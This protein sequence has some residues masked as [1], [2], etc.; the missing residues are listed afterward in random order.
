[1]GRQK[2]SPTPTPNGAGW[3]LK[4]LLKEL[5][6]AAVT[7]RGWIEPSD[8]KRYVLPILFLRFHSLRYDR[9][10]VELE[11]RIAD[12]NSDYHPTDTKAAA[13]ILNDPDEYQAAGAF[14]VP[15]PARWANVAAAARR[16]DVKLQVDNLL[17]LLETSYPTPLR[18]LLPR[19]YADPNL[20]A[21]NLRGLIN[22]FS[23]Y[24]FER[25]QP[26]TS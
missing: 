1:M 3:S 8:Y 24:E 20:D 19:I 7:L 22:L 26:A 4:E 18:S 11:R 6:E 10:R 16:D 9:R 15:E 17:E 5:W 21:E 25:G 2:K 14:V 13:R 12:P 23:K